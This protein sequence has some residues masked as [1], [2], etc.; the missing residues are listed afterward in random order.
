MKETLIILRCKNSSH[1]IS[2]TLKAL[3]SQDYKNFELLVLDSGSSDDT[4]EK[5]AF[6]KHKL[7]KIEASS[8][9]PG[10]VLNNA[11]LQNNNKLI[12]FLNSDTVMLS[13]NCLSI[14]V[15]ELK[16][17]DTHAV[18]ARQVARSDAK[19]WVK[20]DYEISFPKNDKNPQWIYFSLPFAGI[21]KKVWKDTHFY[22][23]AWASEDTKMGYDLGKKSLHVKYLN[24]CIVMHSH[25]YNLKQIYNRRFVEAEADVYIFNNKYAAVDFIKAYLSSIYNDF[26][27]LIKDYEI[28]EIFLSIVRR[29]VYHYAYYKG[30]IYGM[31]RKLMK[32]KQSKGNYQ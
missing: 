4:L 10:R 25:N 30:Y 17:K 22:T 32:K 27:Y 24:T 16:Q 23:K 29:F 7:I 9:H 26:K 13:P 31:K 12:V 19:P 20:R 5:V 2:Q 28:K 1:I 21:K 15:N 6:Y 11:I 3:F 8:Y 14:L 18:F